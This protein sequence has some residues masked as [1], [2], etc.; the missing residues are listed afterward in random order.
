MKLLKNK[1]TA[2]IPA[3]GRPTN[4]IIFNNNLP[5]AMLPINGKP[6]IG[7]I[8]EDLMSRKI[9]DVVV[10]LNKNDQHTGKYIVQKYGE[11]CNLKIIYDKGKRGLGYSIY[12]GANLVSAGK[13][14]VYLGDTI[15]KGPL[16]FSHSFLVVSDKFDDSTKWCFVEKKNKKLSFINKPE[17]YN[18]PGKI[19]CGLYYFS[20]GSLLKKIAG[21]EELGKEIVD[22]YKIISDYAIQDCPRLIKSERWY[23]CG[24]IENYYQAKID[25]LRLRGFNSIKY[26]DLFGIITKTG[27][28]KQKIRDEINWY[29]NLPDKL[30]IFTP[31]VLNCRANVKQPSYSLEYYGYQSLDDIF[32]FGYLDEKIWR[33]IIERLL[34]IVKLFKKY[35]RKVPRTDYH[36]MY[37]DKMLERLEDLKE[38]KRW[39]KILDCSEIWLNGRTYKNV[40]YFRPQIE[41]VANKMYDSS[42]MGVVHGD[43][44]LNNILFDP[45]NRLFK[46]ID[47][48]GRFGHSNIYGD[49]KYDLAKLRFSL[50]GH[51]DFIVSDLF[52]VKMETTK[53]GD[54]FFCHDY[55]DSYHQKIGCCLDNL[56]VKHGH[57]LEKIKIIEAL[58]YL[59]VVPHHYDYPER[60]LAMYLTAVKKLN[61]VF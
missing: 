23:D 45:G 40:G 26:D 6:V 44:C 48:R 2:I 29:L 16:G 49:V 7:Y 19:I 33:L 42:E 35:G 43:L 41:K 37:R 9:F 1:I 38:D 47:P 3:A 20:D 39:R 53:T 56:L 55:S 34:E 58:L 57:D 8:L 50:V 30:K 11:R 18:S 32:I 13:I 17:F 46:L 15:Y 28:R 24:N 59:S 52:K 22:W 10:V 61:E 5:D 12:L 31:R 27:T 36:L 60:Q 4:K 25:F 14:L 54:K 51:Y 21:K